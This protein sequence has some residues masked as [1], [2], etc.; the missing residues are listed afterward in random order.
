MLPIHNTRAIVTCNCK[1]H[2]GYMQKTN[3]KKQN[4][5]TCTHCCT[6]KPKKHDKTYFFF[7][8]KNICHT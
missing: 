4:N 7:F 8:K 1:Q 5:V 6:V 3:I 2:H